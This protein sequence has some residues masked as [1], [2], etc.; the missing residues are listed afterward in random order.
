MLRLLPFFLSRIAKVVYLMCHPAVPVW[1][2][3]LPVL[4]MAYAIMPQD[5]L[6]DHIPVVGWIDDIWVMLVLL[7]I[8]TYSGG[9]YAARGPRQDGKSIPTTYEVLDELDDDGDGG[10]SDQGDS[11]E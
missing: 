6:R 11:P 2:K 7:T 1:L 8:F 9:R 10:G 4:A 5:L 3:V